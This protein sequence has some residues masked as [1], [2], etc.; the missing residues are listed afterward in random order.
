MICRMQII[1]EHFRVNGVELFNNT[2]IFYGIIAIN[3]KCGVDIIPYCDIIITTICSMQH[4]S[5]RV[6][7]IIYNDKQLAGIK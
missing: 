2:E 6:R 1:K 3:V 5:T 7:R 4:F